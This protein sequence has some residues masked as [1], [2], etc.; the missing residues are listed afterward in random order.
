MKAISIGELTPGRGG[1]END[2]PPL[3]DVPEDE[4]PG[5]A[6]AEGADADEAAEAEVVAGPRWPRGCLEYESR[7]PP[8]TNPFKESPYRS[9][10]AAEAVA[11]SS[12]C[13][14]ND[15]KPAVGQHG[16][17]RSSTRGE[18]G[19]ERKADLDK[20]HGS[21]ALLAEA[22]PAEALASTE[23]RPEG[24]LEVGRRMR[25]WWRGR[26]VADVQG[27]DLEGEKRDREG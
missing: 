8:L 6:V 4:A 7:I 2:S 25:R 15:N 19:R 22:H 3:L 21:V 23:Q 5:M 27:V 26:Q 13:E 12:N 24:V 18:K 17:A 20:A 14:I 11:T 9:R 10:S 1:E 16:A